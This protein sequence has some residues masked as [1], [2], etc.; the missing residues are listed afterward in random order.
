MDSD[1]PKGMDPRTPENARRG[2]IVRLALLV[3]LLVF[4]VLGAANA[5]ESWR[6][7]RDGVTVPGDVIEV[8]RIDDNDGVSWKAEFCYT[9]NGTRYC[10]LDSL[11]ISPPRFQVGDR[12]ELLVDPANPTSAQLNNW[13]SLWLTPLILG[14]AWSAIVF[15]VLVGG[16]RRLLKPQAVL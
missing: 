2:L 13:F 6:L 4:S 10:A 11:A 9:V 12:V 1:Y 8:H 7:L 16:F 15:N 5:V 3:M 14:L